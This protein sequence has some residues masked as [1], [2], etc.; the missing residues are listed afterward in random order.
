MY[1]PVLTGPTVSLRAI[2]PR[3]T[4]TLTLT[5]TLTLYVIVL[6]SLTPRGFILFYS[7]PEVFLYAD[8]RSKEFLVCRALLFSLRSSLPR[9][10]MHAPAVPA[11]AVVF[12]CVPN[13]SISGVEARR[14]V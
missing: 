9:T 7:V 12:R 11:K 14:C 6:L 4:H 13:P 1:S 2:P 5:L 8:I 3:N 10:C